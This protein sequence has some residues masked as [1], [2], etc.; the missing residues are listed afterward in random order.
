MY[1]KMCWSHG[2]P[3][4][5]EEDTCWHATVVVLQLFKVYESQ[6]EGQVRTVVGVEGGRDGREGNL[7]EI[8]MGA[9]SGG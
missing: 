6:G 2:S 7:S 8:R 4:Q 3:Y 5:S 1:T 9:V